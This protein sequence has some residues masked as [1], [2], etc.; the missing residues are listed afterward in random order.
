MSFFSF[1]NLFCFLVDG[2]GKDTG[3]QETARSI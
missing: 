3:M 1:V 2:I